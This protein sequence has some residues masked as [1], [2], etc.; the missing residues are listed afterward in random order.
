LA[1]WSDVLESGSARYDTE[2]IILYQII[3]GL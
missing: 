3:G 2:C 1:K